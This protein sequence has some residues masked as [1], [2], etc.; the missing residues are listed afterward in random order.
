M[1]K[2]KIRQKSDKRQTKGRQAQKFRQKSDKRQ[3]RQKSSEKCV[4]QVQTKADKKQTNIL[5]QPHILCI[6]SYP[7]HPPRH[8]L[9]Q[10]IVPG[11][12]WPASKFAVML[13]DLCLPAEPAAGKSTGRNSRLITSIR[14]TCVCVNNRMHQPLCVQHCPSIASVTNITSFSSNQYT[15]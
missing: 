3:T 2:T 10:P 5:H 8:R 1:C 11:D 15:G 6:T 4:K 9:N 14:S 13:I 12:Q 7:P